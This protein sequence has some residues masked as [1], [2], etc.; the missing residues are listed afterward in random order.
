[1]KRRKFIKSGLAASSSPLLITACQKQANKTNKE[2]DLIKG[3]IFSDAHIGWKGK[4]QPSRNEQSDAIQVIKSNFPDLNLVFDTGD[5]HHGNLVESDRR[6]ARDFWLSEMA[7]A[8]PQALFHYVPGNHELG[9][10]ISDAEITASALGSVVLRPYYSFDYKGIHFISLPQLQN[11]ILISKESL[12]WLEQDLIENQN[13][14]TLVFSHNSIEGTTF[15]NNET[16]YRVTVNSDAVLEVLNKFNNVMAWFHGHNHQYE[17]VKKNQ[18]LYVSNGRIGGFNPPKQWGNFGQ[19]NLGGVYFEISEIGLVVRCFSATNNAFFDELESLQLSNKIIKKTSFNPKG[20]FNYYWGHGMVH[21]NMVQKFYNHYLTKQRTQA[22]IYLNQSKTLNTNPNF[23]F[24]T[25][26]NFAG[27]I[28]NK[29]IGYQVLPRRVKFIKVKD[30]VKLIIG[31]INEINIHFPIEKY[32]R[33]KYLNRS[34]YY[35]CGLGDR[36]SLAI[37]L[38]KQSEIEVKIKVLDKNHQKCYESK[39]WMKTQRKG[40]LSQIQ[41]EI[42]QKLNT[43][44]ADNK[45]YLFIQLKV[46]SADKE[47]I[48]KSIDLTPLSS[49]A[50]RDHLLGL[51]ID[52]QSFT[53]LNKRE[54]LKIMKKEGVIEAKG[55]GHP[56]TVYLKTPSIDWQI[57]NAIGRI[58]ENG[59]AIDKLRHGFMNKSQVIITPTTALKKYVNELCGITKCQVDYH[60]NKIEI[61]GIVFQ[62]G[63]KAKVVVVSDH[64]P[65]A[66]TGAQFE[67]KSINRLELSVTSSQISIEY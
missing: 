6:S 4:D 25:S 26:Y 9:R 16:A 66:I 53:E 55:Q 29:I 39:L 59:F 56:V 19:D 8:F 22:S 35:R 1:M 50:N 13:K 37:D 28:R 34:G 17:I 36:Y 47:V 45:L 48:V 60:K 31:D 15:T 51:E 49:A 18:R 33:E 40:K 23:I 67:L 24:D 2:K 11:T 63:T 41:F 38:D 54:L 30:G 46:R 10:G 27:G 5:I 65:K 12:N 44:A 42:P 64:F 20:V 43:P 7:G 61:S 57:R 3:F 58:T 62:T 21:G 52:G 32:K 14:T